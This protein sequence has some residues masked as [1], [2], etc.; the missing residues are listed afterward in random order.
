MP[1]PDFART[2]ALAALRAF[3]PTVLSQRPS[4][5]L[6]TLAR[7]YRE[8]R[9]DVELDE[10]GDMLL[11]E[12]GPVHAFG[13]APR[14]EFAAVRQLLWDDA[15]GEQVI[16]QLR[17]AWDTSAPPAIR[18]GHAWCDAP[19]ELEAWLDAIRAEVPLASLDATLGPARLEYEQA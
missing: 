7:W 18:S 6:A 1:G 17:L 5:A 14:W 2:D 19:D 4:Q 12:W 11:A 3:A 10:D 13:E 15:D 9:A 16:W 8:A